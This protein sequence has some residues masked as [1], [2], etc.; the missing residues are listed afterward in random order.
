[1]FDKIEASRKNHMPQRIFQ[2]DAFTDQPYRG[3]PACVCLLSRAKDEDWM[4]A[5]AREMNIPAT[6]FLLKDGGNSFRLR[7]FTTTSELALCGHATLASAHVLWE[8]GIVKAGEGIFFNTL[9]GELTAE[10][11]GEWIELD[12]PS[13]P[14]E[15]ELTVPR[16]LRDALG[17]EL[18]R[19]RRN[20]FDYLV[21]VESE[22]VL[23][24]LK[25]DMKLLRAL[26][27]RGVIVTS[28]A[29]EAK[30][31][32][33]SRFFAP[34]VGIDE[35]YVT[36]SAHCCL[37]PYWAERLG[38][39]E[40]FAY[41]ASTRGGEVRVK[42]AGERVLLGGRAVTALRGELLFV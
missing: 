25:P 15:D 33:V 11:A 40:M 3:N 21:E 37:G 5:V 22:R 7:W 35:D 38:Q 2:V 23:R 34:S 28:R 10:R 18:D 24:S 42:V 12:F 1:M 16:E 4:L 26:P 36:G 39:H 32:F 30:Y 27:V 29:A 6:A 19:V 13:E 41:Q 17:V 14:A 8:E 31:D 9:S 20:R